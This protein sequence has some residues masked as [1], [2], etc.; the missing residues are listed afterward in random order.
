MAQSRSRAPLQPSYTFSASLGADPVPPVLKRHFTAE[1]LQPVSNSILPAASS[2]AFSAST[3]RSLLSRKDSA[4][5]M[6]PMDPTPTDPNTI[7]LHPPFTNFP[8]AEKYSQGL[9][10]TVMADNENWFL[11]PQDFVSP[12]NNNQNAIPYP[13]QLEPPRGWCPAKKK[14]L[15]ERGGEPWPEGQEPRLRCTFCRRTYAGVNAKSMWRRHVYE[16]HKIA[17]ANRRDTTNPDRSRRRAGNK[18]NWRSKEE[19]TE[20]PKTSQENG[21][22]SDASN[23]RKRSRSPMTSALPAPTPAPVEETAALPDPKAS[24]PRPLAAKLSPKSMP[25]TPSHT[26]G[27]P[28]KSLTPPYD[29]LA[30]PSFRH[31]TP[32]YPSDQPW[33]FPS[34]SH[35][36]HSAARDLSLASFIRNEVT[37][38]PGKG[39]EVSPIVL[40][41]PDSKHRALGSPSIPTSSKKRSFWQLNSLA[42]RTPGFPKPSP[43]RLF[44]LPTPRRWTLDSPDNSF[45]S[46]KSSSS[47]IFSTSSVPSSD[48]PASP[49]SLRN[50]GLLEPI[51][52]AGEDPFADIYQTWPGVAEEDAKAK[53]E[54][55]NPIASE[56]S[57]VVRTG[58]LPVIRGAPFSSP[59]AGINGEFN[60][61]FPDENLAG[62]SWDDMLPPSKRRRTD[63]EL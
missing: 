7:F 5:I 63:R 45:R 10:Y 47:S 53:N 16:K 24:P 49:A 20:E 11:D 26:L 43:R 1:D 35:P 33:R 56:D 6:Y 8:N 30:T 12:A 42:N 29:P 37:S 17:M 27:S 46:S 13:A 2:Q 38:T 28:L 32:R 21:S 25:F 48:S 52:L 19:K 59:L 9:T 51:R 15:K 61:L 58:L 44:S 50:S 14:D 4:H 60:S 34:P 40:G 36:L 62:T 55:T 23:D 41:P 31:S 54:V 18:E 3:S 57:P 22:E 39:L